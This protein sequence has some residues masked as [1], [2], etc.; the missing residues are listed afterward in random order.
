MSL[1]RDSLFF[2]PKDN[3]VN[4]VSKVSKGRKGSKGSAPYV[5]L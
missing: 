2:V 5:R 4:K 1:A 3:K